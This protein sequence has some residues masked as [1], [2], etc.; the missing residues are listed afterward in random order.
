MK[1]LMYVIAL[2]IVSSVLL[3]CKDDLVNPVEEEEKVEVV[4]SGEGTNDGNEPIRNGG[5]KPG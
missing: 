5:V 3:S 2:S 1:K 4:P